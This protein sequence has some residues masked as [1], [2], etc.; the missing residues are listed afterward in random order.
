MSGQFNFSD[1]LDEQD[2][3][4]EIWDKGESIASN[5]KSIL[6]QS[7]ILPNTWSYDLI[8][9]YLLFPSA[10]AKQCPI[11]FLYGKSG[12]GKSTIGKLA[13]KLYDVSISA[14]D[15]T[16]AAIRN[17]IHLRKFPYN[18]G[19]EENSILIWDDI[20]PAVFYNNPVIY[21][22]LKVGYDRSTGFIQ[23]ASQGGENLTFG[24]FLPKITC[25]ITALHT[26]PEFSE[27][28]RRM[29]IIPTKKWEEFTKEEQE[30]NN[31]DGQFNIN[32]KLNIDDFNWYGIEKLIYEFWRNPSRCKSY[33]YLRKK[34]KRHSEGLTGSRWTISVDLLATGL[35]TE[36]W[37]SIDEAINCIKKYWQWFKGTCE[38]FSLTQEDNIIHKCWLIY[39]KKDEAFKSPLLAVTYGMS[40]HYSV[41]DPTKKW[42]ICS[43]GQ[44]LMA[45]VYAYLLLELQL[46]PNRQEPGWFNEYLFKA[47]RIVRYL[48]EFKLIDLGQ[49]ER[50][51]CQWNIRGKIIS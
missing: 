41:I 43:F 47:N 29:L 36:V 7:V 15:N 44:S 34:L 38:V 23:I 12:S 30:A 16:A 50:E 3:W 35:A 31:K 46:V 32:E 39:G 14:P 9:A 42:I 18:D 8:T 37:L 26:I 17:E 19:I 22:I 2:S 33:I 11:L 5:I 10:L 48:Y 21:R 40:G 45:W 1:F 13:S 25:S 20:D 24:V 51:M 28:A 4:E 49:I 27:L 6:K